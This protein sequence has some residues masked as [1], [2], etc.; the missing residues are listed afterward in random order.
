MSTVSR[1]TDNV[2]RVHDVVIEQGTAH[3]AA[4]AEGWWNLS[5]ED[6][7]EAQRCVA[8]MVLNLRTLGVKA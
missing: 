5:R 8:D 1:A 2:E 3:L 4:L 7:R 6:R